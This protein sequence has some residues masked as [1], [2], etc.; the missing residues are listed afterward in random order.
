[1]KLAQWMIV[2]VVLPCGQ[3]CFASNLFLV[4]TFDSTITSDPNAAAIESTINTAIAVYEATFSDPIT[5]NILFQE[6]GGLGSSSTPIGSLSY[7]AFRTALVADAKT[8]D[9]STA[10][11]HLPLTLPAVLDPSG[12]GNLWVTTANFRALGIPATPGGTACGGVG[13]DGTITLNTSLTTPG[14]P[15]TTAQYDLQA[16]VEHEID[17][18]LGM[19]SGLN[20]PVGFPR[21]ARPQD[22]FRYD[23][24]GGRSFDTSGSVRSFFSIDGTTLLVEFN[25]NGSADYGDWKT[26]A[27]P[28]QVQDAFATPGSHPLLGVELRNLDVIG[29]DSAVPEP[30]SGM[31]FGA[32]LVVLG[33][34]G[35]RINVPRVRSSD[36]A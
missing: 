35:R 8:S 15:V 12:T 5:V 1:M 13:C 30:S 2:A 6:G 11:S 32:G 21:Y 29:Y 31:L 28:P 33:L 9:D 20:L 24:I 27:A 16:V 25:Q 17:E 34:I 18:V 4:P 7:V 22:L 14:S 26:G 36:T 19:G 10:L 23:N 3:F